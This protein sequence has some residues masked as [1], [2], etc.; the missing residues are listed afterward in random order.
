MQGFIEQMPRPGDVLGMRQFIGLA[1]YMARFIPNLSRL[2]ELLQQFTH[3][4]NTY[5]WEKEHEEAISKVKSE[6]CGKQ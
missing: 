2:L 3:K 5:M 6:E 4:N 1:N